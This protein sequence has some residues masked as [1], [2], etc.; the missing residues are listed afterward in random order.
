MFL[1]NFMVRIMEQAG[2]VPA[3]AE[4]GLSPWLSYTLSDMM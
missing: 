1:A 4:D 2:P 3:P